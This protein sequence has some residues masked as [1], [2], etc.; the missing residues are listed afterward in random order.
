MSTYEIDCDQSILKVTQMEIICTASV[1]AA[2]AFYEPHKDHM[3]SKLT[4][5]TP[6][7]SNEYELS[8]IDW[9]LFDAHVEQSDTDTNEEDENDPD[10]E[11][12]NLVF[13]PKFKGNPAQGN[14]FISK[15]MI[16]QMIRECSEPFIT[17]NDH[18]PDEKL[19]FD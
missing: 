10:E 16:S 3:K 19:A 7:Y 12:D 18:V 9:I 2:I 17:A 1:D 11:D 5:L 6:L 14:F 8:A 15:E 4:N 13:E